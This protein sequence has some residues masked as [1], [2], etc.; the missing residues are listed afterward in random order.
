MIHIE[1]KLLIIRGGDGFKE[2]GDLYDFCLSVFIDGDNAHIF[3]LCGK[4]RWSDYS[5]IREKLLSMGVKKAHWERKKNGKTKTVE[6][7]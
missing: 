3:G 4:F 6:W 7:K 5:E 2:Y 1:P